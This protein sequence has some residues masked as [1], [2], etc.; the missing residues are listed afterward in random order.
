MS[1]MDDAF[2]PPLSPTEAA[3]LRRRQ[4]GRNVVLLCVLVGLAALFYAIS[5]VKFK[6]H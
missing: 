3:D 1:P 5:I 2:P 4:R 6:V